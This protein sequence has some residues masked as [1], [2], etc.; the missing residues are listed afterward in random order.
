MTSN[1]RTSSLTRPMLGALAALTLMAALA[2]LAAAGGKLGGGMDGGEMAV[3]GSKLGAGMDGVGVTGGKNGIDPGA[4][5]VL[6]GGKLGGGMDRA[7]LP[8]DRPGAGTP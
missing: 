4:A 7:T 5:P 3:S 2:T 1:G 8:A 6:A